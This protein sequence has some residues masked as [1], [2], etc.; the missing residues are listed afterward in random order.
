[1]IARFSALSDRLVDRRA[2]FEAS[3][4]VLM[5]EADSVDWYVSLGGFALNTLGN[6]SEAPAAHGLDQRVIT[7]VKNLREGRAVST[8]RLEAFSSWINSELTELHPPERRFRS[9]AISFVFSILGARAVGQGQNIAGEEGVD[10][11]KIL[12]AEAMVARGRRVE[13]GDADSPVSYFGPDDLSGSTKVLIERHLVF[14]FGGGGSRLDVEIRDHGIVIAK[15]EV[16]ARKDTSNQW[17][18]WMPQVEDQLKLWKV[19]S[20]DAARLFFGVSGLPILHTCWSEPPRVDS[21]GWLD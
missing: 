2:L 16:K 6:L 12:M 13:V 3:P 20:P 10:L 11:L 15:G 1:M 5:D 18:S 19:E 4:A 14:D 17:E 21:G 8:E 7:V 9:R